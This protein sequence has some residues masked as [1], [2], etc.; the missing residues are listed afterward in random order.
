MK[1]MKLVALCLLLILVPTAYLTALNLLIP[2]SGL[3]FY[4]GWADSLFQASVWNLGYDRPV[5]ANMSSEN[6]VLKVSAVGDISSGTLVA[7]Q[8]WSGLDFNM[9]EY[10]YLKVSIMTSG[11]T[12]AAR[13]VIWTDNPYVVLLKTYNDHEWHTEVLDVVYTLSNM[14]ATSLRPG[15]IELSWQQVTEG[16]NSTVYYSQLSFNSLETA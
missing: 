4:A 12:V 6:G 7:A 2:H 8:R 10:K 15:M 3:K 1:S 16:F 14:G 5:D 13:I 9:S 11:I